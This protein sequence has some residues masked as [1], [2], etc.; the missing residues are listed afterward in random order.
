MRLAELCGKPI[1]GKN[2]TTFGVVHEVRAKGGKVEALDCGP[3]SFLKRMTGRSKGRRIP[4]QKVV[5]VTEAQIL[6]DLEQ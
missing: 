3:G 6:V 5:A 1:V 2:G 4:W